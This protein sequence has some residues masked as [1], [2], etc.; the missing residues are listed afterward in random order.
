[1]FKLHFYFLDA[2]KFCVTFL[3]CFHLC[4]FF[5]CE[6]ADNGFFGILH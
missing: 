2:E 5:D 3:L 4:Q 1:M 6:M